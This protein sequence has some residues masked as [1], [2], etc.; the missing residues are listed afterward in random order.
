MLHSRCLPLLLLLAPPLHPQSGTV[1]HRF[2]GSTTNRGCGGALASCGDINADGVPD[3]LVGGDQ[4]ITYGPT[5]AYVL[6]GADGSVL[7]SWGGFTNA[8]AV[9]GA[10]DVDADGTPDLLIGSLWTNSKA[11]QAKVFSGATGALLYTLDGAYGD[12]Y[13]GNAVSGAGDVDHDGYDDLLIGA[14]G[15]SAVRSYSGTAY[16]YSGQTG[17]IIRRYEGQIDHGYFGHAV[18]GM[19]DVDGDGVPD[20]L[21]GELGN[22]TLGYDTG[23]AYLFSGATGALIHSWIGPHGNSRFGEHLAALG[24]IDQDGVDDCVIAAM[25]HSPTGRAYVISGA[26]GATIHELAGYDPEEVFADAVGPAGDIDADGVPDI[27]VGSDRWYTSGGYTGMA[28]VFSG[29][30]GREIQRFSPV[31]PDGRCGLA[32]SGVG[33]WNGDGLGDYAVGAPAESFQGTSSGSVYI[34]SGQLQGILFTVEQPI[35]GATA[36]FRIAGGTPNGVALVGYSLA[37][38]GPTATPYGDVAMSSPIVTQPTLTLDAVGQTTL[39]ATL[40][41]GLAGRSIWTQAVD[42]AS[43]SLSNPNPVLVQ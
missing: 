20:Q 13:F 19:G 29:V 14:W 12:N 8:E 24:D 26:T 9:A 32:V 4:Y 36:T 10:G 40:P 30:D 23:A 33:D 18:A 41:P 27:L 42:L 5:E 3:L 34:V 38:G 11:G 31:S 1:L 7:F 39:L 25:F 16:L 22:D 6:S 28:R 43:G 21:I 2:D 17:A 35:A 15:E 37:G